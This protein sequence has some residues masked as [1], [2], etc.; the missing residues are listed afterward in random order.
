[1]KSCLNFAR[2]PPSPRPD[3]KT[4]H[5]KD[6]KTAKK[7]KKKREK[8]FFFNKIGFS[9]LRPLR[10]CGANFLDLAALSFGRG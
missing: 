4:L 7:D 5:R 8:V 2:C 1:M 3:G 6:A 10:L 9:S